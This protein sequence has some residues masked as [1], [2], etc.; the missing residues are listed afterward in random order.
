MTKEGVTAKTHNKMTIIFQL[1][2]LKF[3]EQRK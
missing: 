2:L 1:T 3:S